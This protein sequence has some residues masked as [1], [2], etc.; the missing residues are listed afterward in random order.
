M[1]DSD[2]PEY[3]HG[4]K[5]PSCGAIGGHTRSRFGPAGDAKNLERYCRECNNR[6][7]TAHTE[8]I[9]LEYDD[10]ESP[11]HEPDAWKV[12]AASS[13]NDAKKDNTIVREFTYI[14]AHERK[15]KEPLYSSE[16]IDNTVKFQQQFRDIKDIGRKLEVAK[17]NRDWELVLEMAK[18]CAEKADKIAKLEKVF[19][20]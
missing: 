8:F 4:Y 7:I 16:T 5:C 20:E 2:N 1:S 11:K 19:S 17:Q 10:V 9:D 3:S 13:W 6:F 14:P 15:S 18:E 12:W